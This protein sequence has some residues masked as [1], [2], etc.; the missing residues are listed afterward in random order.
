MF[1]E[2]TT[3]NFKTISSNLQKTFPNFVPNIVNLTRNFPN[4]VVN[5]QN[6]AVNFQKS[7]IFENFRKYFSKF[8]ENF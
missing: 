3:E 4:F 5:N 8:S 2:K 7:T 6:F 1:S